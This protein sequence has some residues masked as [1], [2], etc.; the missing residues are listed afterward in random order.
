MASGAIMRHRYIEY[1]LTAFPTAVS[2]YCRGFRRNLT[3][4][5]HGFKLI[6]RV[7]W[8]ERRFA[9]GIAIH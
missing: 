7:S 8:E 2:N 1:I 6:S 9:G 3:F 5:K 4:P